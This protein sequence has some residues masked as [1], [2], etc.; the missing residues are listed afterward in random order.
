MKRRRWDSKTKAK[1]VLEGLAGRSV[2]EIYIEYGIYQNQFHSWRDQFLSE[3]H[4]VFES[5]NRGGELQ[6]LHRKKADLKK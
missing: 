2:S 4:S 5:K 6:R 1:I 3:A